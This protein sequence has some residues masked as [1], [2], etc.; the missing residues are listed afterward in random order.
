MEQVRRI[1]GARVKLLAGDRGYRGQKSR[2]QTKIEIPSVP[3]STDTAYTK[4]KKHRLFRKRARIEPVI[5]HCKSGHRLSRN[6]YKG[7]FG[8]SINVMLAAAAFNFKRVM[9]LLF[10]PIRTLVQMAFAWL[11][12]GFAILRRGPQKT[13]LITL[14][15]SEGLAY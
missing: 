9:D 4:Q 8:D 11:G 5:G 12:M 2:G 14:T 13:S 3:K 10:C 6:F 15:T 1:Y 7:L